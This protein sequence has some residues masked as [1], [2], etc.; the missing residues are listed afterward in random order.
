MAEYKG[1]LLKGLFTQ[2]KNVLLNNGQ[3]VEETINRGFVKVVADGSKSYTQLF[4]ELFALVNMSKVTD[5]TICVFDY[6]NAA[7]NKAHYLLSE[8]S[9]SYLV[10]NRSVASSGGARIESYYMAAT[11]SMYMVATGTTRSDSSAT[12]PSNGWEFVIYY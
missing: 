12:I 7:G 3:S 8:L 10:F 5:R 11:G 1:K 9:N 6:Q 4:N 2:A